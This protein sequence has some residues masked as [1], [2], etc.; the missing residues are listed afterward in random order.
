[1]T[2]ASASAK[3]S[4]EFAIFAPLDFVVACHSATEVQRPWAQP[5]RDDSS[6]DVA[7]PVVVDC[8]EAS[9]PDEPPQAASASAAIATTMPR[10]TI[11]AVSA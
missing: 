4:F 8:G 6:P 7:V 1:V 10:I 9:S 11:T 3:S 2:A 5:S